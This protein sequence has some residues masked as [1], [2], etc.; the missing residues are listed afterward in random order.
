M[1]LD[2]SLQ[3]VLEIL[4][5]TNSYQSPYAK[6]VGDP[7]PILTP[8]VRSRALTISLIAGAG[9]FLPSY[10]SYAFS[11]VE[12]SIILKLQARLVKD[13]AIIFGKEKELN[14]DLLFYCLFKNTHPEFWKG[15]VRFIGS[16]VL[17]RPTSYS[18]FS[19]LIKKINLQKRVRLES[20]LFKNLFF[21]LSSVSLSVLAYLDTKI[22]AQTAIQ[23]FSKEIVFEES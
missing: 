18:T 15:F 9:N 12:I 19:Q 17:L 5:D 3:K 13:I 22:V 16:R 23:V 14:K 1:N 8:L 4:L 7:E 10:I 6:V 11:L 20:K 21:I 2:D